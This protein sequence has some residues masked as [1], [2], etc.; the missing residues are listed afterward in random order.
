MTTHSKSLKPLYYLL[1]VQWAFAALFVIAPFG[2]DI[3]SSWGLDLNSFI[4]GML[5]LGILS[6]VAVI[7][8]LSTRHP[9]C[10]V[11]AV[12][13]IVAGLLKLVFT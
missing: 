5:L 6:L 1:A 13:P 12:L 7:W 4:A 3:R 9:G 8:A 10:V 11:L 2:F